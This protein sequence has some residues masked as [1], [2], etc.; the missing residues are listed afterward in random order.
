MSTIGYKDTVCTLQQKSKD[1]ADK[2]TKRH[3]QAEQD[4]KEKQTL[5]VL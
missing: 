2:Q 5:M 4:K 1:R 3:K